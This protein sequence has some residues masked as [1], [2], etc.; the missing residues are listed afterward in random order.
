[1]LPSAA[2]CRKEVPVGY[3]NGRCYAPISPDDVRAV[4]GENSYDVATLCMSAKINM[5]ARFKP[6][7]WDSPATMALEAR[8]N[9]NF[10]LAASTTY[11][12]K[13]GFI[14]AVKA[15]S[16]TGGWVYNRP[17]AN[18]WKRLDDLVGYNHAAKS[19]FGTL[20]AFS[21]TL[22][23]DSTRSLL[24][25]AESPDINEPDANGIITMADFQ[26]GGYDYKNW[27]FGI[28]LYHT[29]RQF[30][31]TA[32]ATI[33]SNNDWQV[34]F[35]WIN[36]SYAATYKGVPFLSNKPMT[37]SGAEPSDLKIIGVGQT[38]VNV[39]LKTLA[40]VYVPFANC[41]YKTSGSNTVTYFV[42]I[43]N[44][45]SASRTFNKVTLEIATS[46]TGANAVSLVVFGTVTVAAGQKWTKS[47]TA[48]SQGQSYQFCR[49]SY[50]GATSGNWINFEMPDQPDMPDIA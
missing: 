11:T 44:N 26:K 39:V 48:T 24:V 22:Y 10:G 14:N 21:G 40:D 15:G 42:S 37:V 27:Y 38:G 3:S 17:G 33:G 28:L 45:S 16:F 29:S 1:M 49:L 7:I 32:T 6:E 41:I 30:I 8:K 36:P 50:E 47:G 20:R 31:A 12:S 35:G 2:R 34:N 43:Q 46:Y 25:P 19:P 4:I 5:W 9:N 13:L 23:S 18:H